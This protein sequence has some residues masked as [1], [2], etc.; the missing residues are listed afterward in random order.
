MIVTGIKAID[1]LTPY[2]KGGQGGLVRWRGRWQNGL[3]A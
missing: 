2:P 3:D 1:L